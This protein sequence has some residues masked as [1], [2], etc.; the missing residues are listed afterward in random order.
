MTTRE[1]AERRIGKWLESLGQRPEVTTL[2]MLCVG[3]IAVKAEI[4]GGFASN[5]TDMYVIKGWLNRAVDEAQ[6]W[7]LNVDDKGRP[8]K[9]MKFSSIDGIADE[10][11]KSLAIDRQN[12]ARAAMTR[13]D[14]TL[15]HDFGDGFTM[16]GLMTPAALKREGGATQNCIGDGGLYDERLATGKWRYLSLRDRRG[17]SH[18]SLELD[19]SRN[20]VNSMLGKQNRRALPKYQSRLAA[21]IGANNYSYDSTWCMGGAIDANGTLLDMMAVPGKVS[22]N[23]SLYV[24]FL[25]SGVLP[26]EELE[27]TGDLVI[28]ECVLRAIPA[29]VVVGGSVII[30]KTRMRKLGDHVTIVR[31][32]RITGADMGEIGDDVVV[33]GDVDLN[34][35][36][37]LAELPRRLH[38]GGGFNYCQGKAEDFGE[39]TCV[40]G[41][42]DLWASPLEF[43]TAADRNGRIIREGDFVRLA[44]R[45][46]DWAVFNRHWDGKY[47]VSLPSDDGS[48]AVTLT[49]A[50]NGIEW[51][52]SPTL[53]REGDA[54]RSRSIHHSNGNVVVTLDEPDLGDTPRPP[55]SDPF[56]DDFDFDFVDW[57]LDHMPQETNAA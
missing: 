2:L 50:R 29:R 5:D 33:G 37:A 12:R 40:M 56:A 16:V 10:A 3:R 45:G 20:H 48:D 31:D 15:V 55:L 52:H 53:H 9:L 27:V 1:E 26:L 11:R 35:L 28:S 44:D 23:G 30:E 13:D 38:V 57:S 42:M 24:R 7:L 51:Q 21:F 43:R 46:G 39:D 8:R 32:L 49:C 4:G 25:A 17:K 41:S 22:I 36:Y 54:P 14:E 19:V 34:Y 18:A 6:P 47:E